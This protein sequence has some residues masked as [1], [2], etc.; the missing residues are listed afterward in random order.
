MLSEKIESYINTHPKECLRILTIFIGVVWQAPIIIVSLIL[1]CII[2]KYSSIDRKIIYIAGVII[3]V[4]L[5]FW[6][7]NVDQIILV[8][9]LCNKTFWHY[10]LLGV[11]FGSN[12][13]PISAVAER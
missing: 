5:I 1:Y 9:W 4:I 10:M 12:R 2:K 8:G 3:P 13:T 7:G 6:I 11:Y